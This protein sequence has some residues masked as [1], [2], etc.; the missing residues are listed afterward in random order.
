MI[1]YEIK[2]IFSKT[3]CRISMIVLLL[4]L[5]ISC[6]FAITNITYIDE[7]G[8]SHTG[9]AAA[10]DLRTE[11]QK[12]EGTL[13]E[14][15]LQKVLDEY[16]K[17]N[18]EYPIRQ[19]DYTANMLHDSKVQGIS[20]IKD[21]INIGFCKFRDF[22]YYRIDSVSKDEVGK[23]YENR[24]K[25]LE[26]WLGSEDAEGLF[27][28]NEKAFLL[29]RYGQLKAPLYYE[30]YDG[31]RSV[32]HYA[33]TIVMLVMLVSAFLVSGIFSNEFS[34]KAD[35]IFFSTKYGRDKG[36]KAKLTAGLIV[37]TA[38]YWLFIALY[39]IIVLGVLG[40][41]G[42]NVMIQTG[43]WYWKSFYNITYVQLYV[44]TISAGY[45]GT[46]FCMLLSMLISAKT[47]TAVVAVT[48]PFVIFFL[49][50]F[51]SNFHFLE[52]VLGLFPDQLLQ[53]NEII[54]LFNLY[55]IGGKVVGSI[56]IMMVIYPILCVVLLPIIYYIYHKTEIK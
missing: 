15:A 28:E 9:I 56:P 48:I 40:F 53:I 33:Q 5:I 24:V 1:R 51:L 12:W 3:I 54:N 6:Y 43:F 32:L 35:S 4:S 13:D 8:V 18:E 41:G 37:V 38:I 21:M 34:W 26:K 23:L 27:D 55:Q 47:H 14:E 50:L 11:K 25:S 42:G 30:D 29:E 44:L 45:I 2:K 20:E 19:G 52:G 10:R 46:L 7:Q 17:I 39:S 49:P 22:N 31:W 16:R 36:T